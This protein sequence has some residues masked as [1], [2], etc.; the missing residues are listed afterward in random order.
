MQT[1]LSICLYQRSLNTYRTPSSCSILCLFYSLSVS[2]SRSRII[3]L[4]LASSC[5]SSHPL[6]H[7][8]IL[9]LTLASSC[10]LSH[11]LAPSS[12]RPTSVFCSV[13]E[14]KISQI[15]I[16]KKL[17]AIAIFNSTFHQNPWKMRYKKS[18]TPYKFRAILFSTL[19][20]YVKYYDTK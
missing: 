17:N 5:S 2:F 18:Q 7:S 20:I 9:L 8:C 19:F 15:T 6:V 16:V 10:S 12:F 1:D 4:T 3:L 11:P 13:M 14:S